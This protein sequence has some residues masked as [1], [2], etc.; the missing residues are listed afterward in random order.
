MRYKLAFARPI[1]VEEI[2]AVAVDHIPCFCD[3]DVANYG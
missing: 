1:A 3:K 2:Y